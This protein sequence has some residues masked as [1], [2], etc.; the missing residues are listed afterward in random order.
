[1]A[2]RQSVE[3]AEVNALRAFCA[4][5]REYLRDFGALA[6]LI[7]GEEHSDRLIAF[8]AQLAVDDFNSRG[9]YLGTFLVQNFP[10]ISLLLD[11]TVYRLLESAAHLYARNDLDYSHGGTQVTLRQPSNYL[12]LAGYYR[13]RFERDTLAKKRVLNAAG[14]MAAVGGTYTSALLTYRPVWGL[15]REYPHE[16]SV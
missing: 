5:A 10:S 13:D 6:D 4:Y 9:A 15:F 11:G 7:D 8:C 16:P 12:Q 14:A 3:Q 2:T 1:M